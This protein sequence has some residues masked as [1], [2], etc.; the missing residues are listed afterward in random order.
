MGSIADNLGGARAFTNFLSIAALERSHILRILK[1]IEAFVQIENRPVKK[2]PLL[3]GRTVANLFFEPSTRT[4][5]AFT[6]AATRLSAD[7]L[8]IDVQNLALNKGE[9]LL[10]TLATIENMRCDLFVVRHGLSGAAE[11]IASHTPPEVSIVNAGDGCH[12]HPTQ[13]LVDMYTISRRL[14]EWSKLSVALIG[15]IAH[16]RVARSDMLALS[17]L[18]VRDV[19]AIAPDTLIPKGVEKMGVKVFRDIKEGLRDVDVV[20]AL[21]LQT[22]RMS[23]NF[24]PSPEEYFNSY[25]VTKQALRHAKPGA[26]VMHP[27]PINRGVEISSEVAD[28]PQ[29]VILEQ[30]RYGIAVRMAVMSLCMGALPA[31]MTGPAA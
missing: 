29:A 13:A 27:G 24:L 19:R 21:R 8:N 25:G 1:L 17:L 16:S 26:I 12:E 11:F 28:G 22:E 20:I 18:G 6:M 3:R 9:S 7:V 5:T 23:G 2:V 14:P 10:D 4:R 31:D 15:D 30:V